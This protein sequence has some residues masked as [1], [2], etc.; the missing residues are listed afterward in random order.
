MMRGNKIVTKFR[1]DLVSFEQP[2]D[3]PYKYIVIDFKPLFPNLRQFAF[4]LTF[5]ISKKDIKFFYAFTN[6]D[7]VDW[8]RNEINKNFKW[9]SADFLI[10]HTDKI[11]EFLKNKMSETENKI[12]EI[13]KAKFDSEK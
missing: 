13:T 3:I 11:F 6:Y 9:N 12:V 10:K 8:N 1:N 2:I 4:I 5:L 7:E